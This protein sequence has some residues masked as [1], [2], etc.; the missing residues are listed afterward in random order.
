MPVLSFLGLALAGWG[1]ERSARARIFFFVAAEG[2]L[3]WEVL[4]A[5][6]LGVA[7]SVFSVFF[8][9]V[10]TVALT[11]DAGLTVGSLTV[12]FLAGEALLVAL[13]VI[14]DF[15]VVALPR[16]VVAFLMTFLMPDLMDF[17]FSN[18]RFFGGAEEVSVVSDNFR[19]VPA[20]FAFFAFFGV[21]AF[22]VF[23][24]TTLGR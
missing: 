17:G 23:S 19:L 13:E 22:L 6:D 8:C 10:L 21:A 5:G 11:L 16:A 14:T 18:L 7:F 1:V 24:S 15:L 12:F 2:R 4:F 3:S 9:E 20:V